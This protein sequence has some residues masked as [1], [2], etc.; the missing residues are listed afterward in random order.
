MTRVLAKDLGRP[1]AGGILVNC[2]APGPTGT[3]LFYKGKSEQLVETIGNFS[4][5]ARIGTPEEIAEAVL[6]LAS[7]SWTSGQVLRVNR[8]MA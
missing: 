4:P 2:L 3:D 5:Q 7:S 8:A 1:E 6:F